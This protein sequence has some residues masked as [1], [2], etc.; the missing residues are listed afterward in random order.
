MAVPHADPGQPISI[1]PLGSALADARTSAL[2]KSRDLEVMHLVLHVGKSL[3]PHKVAGEITIQCIEG[4]LV[5][6]VEG[7]ATDLRAGELMFLSGGAV[8]AVVAVSDS[9]AIVTVALKSS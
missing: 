6:D 2:F 3:P 5:V 9:S 7:V 4:Q 1:R 8:H